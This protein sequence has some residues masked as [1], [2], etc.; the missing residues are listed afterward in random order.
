MYSYLIKYFNFGN[1][2]LVV[3]MTQA[4]SEKPAKCARSNRNKDMEWKLRKL[5]CVLLPGL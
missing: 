3:R 5:K 1:L 2:K 4:F